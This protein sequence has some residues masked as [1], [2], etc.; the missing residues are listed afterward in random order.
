MPTMQDVAKAAGVSV[1]TVSATINGSARVSAKLEARVREAIRAVG[2]QPNGIARSLKKGSTKTIGL[3]VTDITNPYF[4]S[5]VRSIEDVAHAHGYAVILCNSDED[6]AKERIYL[7]LLRARMVDGLVFAPAGDA[8]E[9]L[10]FPA[11]QRAPAV[12]L[13]RTVDSVAADAVVVDNAGGSRLAIHH[14]IA[15]GHRRIGFISGRRHLST[16]RER[17]EGYRRALEENGLAFEPALVCDGNFR[18]QD[19]YESA[20][21]LLA[22][23]PRPTAVFAA[24][25]LMAIGLM[26]A[27]K[28]AGL[29]CPDDVSVAC[30]D[31]FDWANVFHPRLTTVAQPTTAIGVQ[32]MTLLLG[33]LQGAPAEAP[34]RRIVL[35]PE[36]IVR[37]S[38]APPAAS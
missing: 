37:D 32:A 33:R 4:T 11:E 19:A 30:F 21:R 20:L 26:L 29:R 14:L 1:A 28:D 24:N 3:V 38:C 10:D 7:E 35:R 2:Y 34:A 15:L 31:D 18:Q 9:Y 25:N 27:I 12:F 36:L 13:D 17:L 23:S 22:R 6:V 5:V 8:G 16:S